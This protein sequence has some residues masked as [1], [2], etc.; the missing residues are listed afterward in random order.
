M[1]RG[2][3]GRARLGVHSGGEQVNGMGGRGGQFMLSYMLR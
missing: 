3:D 2:T 1:A